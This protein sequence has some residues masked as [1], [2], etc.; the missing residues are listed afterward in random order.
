MAELPKQVQA[1]VD[2]AEAISNDLEA[3]RATPPDPANPPSDPAPEVPAEVPPLA[4]PEPAAEAP[5]PAS[6][7]WEQKY[8]TLQGILTADQTRSRAEAQRLQTQ[9]TEQ[10]GQIAELSKASKVAE[11]IQSSV[12]DKDVEAFGS[13]LI[14]LAKR[15]AADTM[16]AER[17]A[18]EAERADMKTKLDAIAAANGTVAQKQEV[19]AKGQYLA[20]LKSLVPDYEAVNADE[21]FLSWCR[22]NDPVAG[23]PRQTFLDQAFNTNDVARTASYFNAWKALAP[24]PATTPDPAPK[25]ATRALERQVTPRSSRADTPPSDPEGT[26]IWTTHEVDTFYRD[27]TKGLYAGRDAERASTEAQIDQAVATGRIK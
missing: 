22:E 8:R 27:I 19:A 12:T 3:A 4:A 11:A 25:P 1:Q 20:N 17:A 21:K 6:E 10:A 5:A 15:I 13:D 18:W 26:R 23:V 7:D 24:T 2:A 9:L 14:D 16:A